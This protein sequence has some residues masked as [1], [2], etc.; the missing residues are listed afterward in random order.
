MANAN[1]TQVTLVNTFDEWRTRT[2]DLIQDRNI[3][4]NANYVKDDFNFT[5]SNG[6]IQI[7]RAAGGTTFTNDNDALI[8]GALTTNTLTVVANAGISGTLNVAQ[9]VHFTG[10]TTN[11]TG[12][13][14][15]C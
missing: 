7:S 3:L 10:N 4:R 1:I 5:L 6:A 8:S 13:R 14:R 9:N 15:Y 2:N 11:I 12:N